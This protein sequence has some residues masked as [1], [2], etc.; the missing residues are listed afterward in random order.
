MIP[1]PYDWA[2]DDEA[3]TA[4]LD[5]VDAALCWAL[6]AIGVLSVGLVLAMFILTIAR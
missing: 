1:A 3:D 2:D 4:P 6:N 5:V